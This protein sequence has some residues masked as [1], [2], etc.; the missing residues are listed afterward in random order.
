ML[1]ITRVVISL[2]YRLTN[3]GNTGVRPRRSA[4]VL[5]AFRDVEASSKWTK[6]VLILFC[7]EAYLLR[8][9][10]HLLKKQLKVKVDEKYFSLDNPSQKI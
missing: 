8:E 4:K 5:I 3:S 9:E 1:S 2:S 6:W 7:K 10:P